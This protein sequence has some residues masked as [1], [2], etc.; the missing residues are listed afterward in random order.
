MGTRKN[1]SIVW[2]MLVIVGLRIGGPVLADHL[3]IIAPLD[4]S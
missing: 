1:A 2:R 4:T 3:H